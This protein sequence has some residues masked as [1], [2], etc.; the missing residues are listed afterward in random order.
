MKYRVINTV[1]MIVLM[2]LIVACTT[3]KHYCNCG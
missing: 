1:C 3:S 2:L